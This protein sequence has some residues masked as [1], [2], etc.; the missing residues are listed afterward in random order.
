MVCKC[1]DILLALV[2]ERHRGT[3]DALI[4]HG[5]YEIRGLE[6]GSLVRHGTVVQLVKYHTESLS[7]ERLDFVRQTSIHF[8]DFASVIDRRG[9]S[10][11]F[12][13]R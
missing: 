11:F 13:T 3:F 4:L 5:L 6:N 2:M 10:V 1:F 8:E 12:P 9:C 7:R